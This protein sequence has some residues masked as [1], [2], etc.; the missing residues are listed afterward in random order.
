MRARANSRRKAAG[1]EVENF[2]LAADHLA[3]EVDLDVEPKTVFGAGSAGPQF[4]EA[5]AVLDAHGLQDFH[6]TARR[7][8]LAHADAVDRLDESRRGAVHDRNFRPVDLDQA[9]IDAEAAQSRDQMLDR[10]DH[11]LRAVAD[12]GA[13]LGHRHFRPV[14]LDAP[15]AAVGKAAAQEHQ[16]GKSF[17]G[18]EDETDGLAGMDANA[19]GKNDAVPES[20]LKARLHH[21]SVGSSR[22]RG[23]IGCHIAMIPSRSCCVGAMCRMASGERRTTKRA[24]LSA[25][26]RMPEQ[27]RFARFA[28]S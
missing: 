11:V 10:A 16:A 26:G 20:G 15:A 25:T 2:A 22:S 18:V 14:G 23:R 19:S 3:L 27:P 13:K 8:E 5:A 9:I 4:G 12:D 24:P 28:M 6:E 1:F 7:R 17:G 21:R